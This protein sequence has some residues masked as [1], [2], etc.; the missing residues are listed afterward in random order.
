MEKLEPLCITGENVK[1]YS[2]C[3]KK[4]QQFKKLNIE[5]PYESA[6]LLLRIYIKELKAGTWADICTLISKTALFTIA[7][8]WKQPSTYWLMDK[9]N[10]VYGDNEILFY[11]KEE[12]LKGKKGNKF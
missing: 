1:W 9:Q 7:H 3:G 11:L 5:L 8:R 6:I 12:I 4:A 10:V 2:H